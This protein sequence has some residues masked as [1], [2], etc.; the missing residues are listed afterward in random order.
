MK[1]P[2]YLRMKWARAYLAKVDG[3]VS[4]QEGSRRTFAVC[5]TLLR[6]RD[7]ETDRAGFSLTPAD[8]LK[9]I[10]DW[11]RKCIPPWTEPEIIHKLNDAAKAVGREAADFKHHV[12]A[13]RGRPE[14][15]L[16]R[17]REKLE[18]EPEFLQSVADRFPKQVEI[19]RFLSDRS[20]LPPDRIDS[21][22]FLRNLYRPGEKVVVFT[23][24]ESQGQFVWSYDEQVHLPSGGP[25]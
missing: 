21:D 13:R 17:T 7:N 18:F 4:G 20:V 2:L 15:A 3:A 22:S 19:Y 9:V 23:V 10:Q 1:A 25:D 12:V 6:D 24:F 5:C 14:P 8:A 16:E 11:N